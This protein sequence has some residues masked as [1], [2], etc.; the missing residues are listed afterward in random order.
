MRMRNATVL[1]LAAALLGTGASAALAQVDVNLAFDPSVAVPGQQVTL[2][3]SL[4][5]LAP[6][7][8]TADFTVTVS[9]AN[10]NTGAQHF[11]V[12]VPDGYTRSAEVPFVVPAL[13]VI[14]QIPS[15]GVLDVTITAT[16]GQQSD[17]AHA[18]LTLLP[19]APPTTMPNLTTLARLGTNLGAALTGPIG[20]LPVNSMTASEVKQ[21][22]R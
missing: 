18:T 22:Y 5:N 12:Q 21:L 19:G 20:T 14:P 15:T 13:P 4:A 1:L 6:T 2:R 17:I 11:T 10:L 16:V 8:V 3:A 7:A 9:Y